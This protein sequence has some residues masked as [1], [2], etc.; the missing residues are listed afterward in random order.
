MK[1]RGVTLV[2][3][4]VVISVISILVIAMGFSYI[5]WQG[6]YRA[7]KATKDLYA[8][9]MEARTMAMTQGRMC[10]ADFNSPVPPPGSG[11]Y[12]IACDPVLNDDGQ[13]DIDSNGVIDAGHEFLESI[14]PKTVDYPIIFGGA[15]TIIDFGKSGIVQ[16]EDPAALPNWS[17]CLTMPVNL[18]YEVIPDYDC[19]NI[20]QTRI[21]MGKL[22]TSILNGG[23]CRPSEIGGD[24][25]A[26]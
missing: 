2:E 18:T 4:I 5:S 20:S 1:E 15:G 22:R 9:L 25:A 23:D 10:F 12:R 6:A 3:L 19:I 11:R 7:E 16:L 14:N 26:K 17:L 24:C 13:G 21:N 8:D